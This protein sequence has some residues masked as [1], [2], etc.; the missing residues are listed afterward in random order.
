MIEPEPD[1]DPEAVLEGEELDQ[2]FRDGQFLEIDFGSEDE[3]PASDD[4]AAMDDGEGD[5]LQAD[6]EPRGPDEAIAAVRHKQSVLS[7]AISPVD[8]QAV[9]TGGQDDVAVL[10][11]LQEAANGNL[12]CLEHRR[13]EGHKD[14]VSQVAFSH[15]GQ[16]AATGSYDGTVR[17]WTSGGDLVHALEGPSKEIEWLLWHPKGHAILAGSADTMA[18]MWWA[19]TGKLM[20]IFA[21]HANSVTCGCWAM[22]GKLICTGSAD[23]GVIVWNPRAGTPQQTVRNLHAKGVTAM[24]SHP[25]A[26]IVVTGAEDGGVKLVQIETG[27]ALP[28]M[29]GHSLSVE[30]IAFN[31]ADSSGM[32]L[33]ATGAMDG[34]VLVWDG[35]SFDVRCTFL[36]SDEG[37]G[38]TDLKWLP[39]SQFTAWL[40]TTAT[41]H[42]VRLF[43]ALNGQAVRTLTGHANIVLTLDVALLGAQGVGLGLQLCIVTG[44]DDKSCRVFL[45]PIER[46]GARLEAPQL[47]EGTCPTSTQMAAASA[48]QSCAAPT[49]CGGA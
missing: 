16:Y 47:P 39:A 33:L 7:V 44:S 5:G 27:R 1:I 14:S 26:P 43:N 24:C 23:C 31:H 21:G 11:R 9:I 30:A 13:L 6:E 45:A 48:A 3:N 41:D 17:I 2:E 37:G 38:V 20:Q 49:Q 15:D 42:T 12:E 36:A 28:P 8:R 40:C 25:D 22:G 4:D 35:K 18:W 10:W 34:K 19:P 29:A 32:L 46:P